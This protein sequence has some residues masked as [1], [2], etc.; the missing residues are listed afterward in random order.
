[1]RS[2]GADWGAA[3]RE[4]VPGTGIRAMLVA[5]SLGGGVAVALSV[6]SSMNAW[7]A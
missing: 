6:L 3:R 1:M 5:A 2:V 7:H 4:A